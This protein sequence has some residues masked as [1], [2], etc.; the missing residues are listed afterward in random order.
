[1]VG[2]SIVMFRARAMRSKVGANLSREI[3]NTGLERLN[4]VLND[5]LACSIV[6]SARTIAAGSAQ[7]ARNASFMSV[8][9]SKPRL[10]PSGN[11]AS[12]GSIGIAVAEEAIRRTLR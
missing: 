7:T 6:P 5:G 1:M 11:V 4:S 10:G 8:S 3:P 9:L 2:E 12:G